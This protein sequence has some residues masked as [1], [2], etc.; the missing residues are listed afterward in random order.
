MVSNKFMPLM[1]KVG[2]TWRRNVERV[3]DEPDIFRSRVRKKLFLPKDLILT[4][5]YS[6]KLTTQKLLTI[7][8]MAMLAVKSIV[9]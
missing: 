3:T 6:K 7:R 2:V 5:Y 8:L 1:E 4:N 9:I